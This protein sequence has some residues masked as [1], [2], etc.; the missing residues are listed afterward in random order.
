MPQYVLLVSVILPTSSLYEMSD[1]NKQYQLI[2]HIMK[3]Y[4]ANQYNMEV[5]VSLSVPF[6]PASGVEKT[7]KRPSPD[8]QKN[9]T[10]NR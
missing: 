5:P 7:V 9:E 4:S 2:E 1:G 3:M 8:G 10:G 6:S